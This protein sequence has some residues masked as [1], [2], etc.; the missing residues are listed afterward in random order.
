[1]ESPRKPWRGKFIFTE[2]IEGI[3]D[4]V[5]IMF[6]LPDNLDMKEELEK[7]IVD[8]GGAVVRKQNPKSYQICDFKID[9][10]YEKEDFQKDYF[11][12]DVYSHTLI[13]GSVEEG[14]FENLDSHFITRVTNSR[15]GTKRLKGKIILWTITE[16]IKAFEITKN[17]RDNDI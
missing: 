11:N 4:L 6:Y 12:G 9:D 14:E 13:R 10:E 16:I 3:E 7:L 1:M 2:E 8:N 5:S 17:G 15:K